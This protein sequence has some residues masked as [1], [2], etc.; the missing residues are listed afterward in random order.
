MT[1]QRLIL[2]NFQCH[3][4]RVVNFDPAVTT[5]VGESDVGKTAILR[6]LRLL[7]L[8]RPSGESYLSDGTT[9][10]FVRLLVDGRRIERLRHNKTVYA[11]D[12]ARYEAVGAEPLAAVSKLLR[13]DRVNFARQLDPHFWFS[14]TPGQVSKELNSIINLS[15]IDKALANIKRE[16]TRAK[17]TADV[18]RR[19]PPTLIGSQPAKKPSKKSRRY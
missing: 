4:R 9:A 16:Y 7:C 19:S 8:N 13:I 15:V 6:A 14:L 5:I 17:T 2:K 12:G 18:C 3:R 11:V 10:G 1:L